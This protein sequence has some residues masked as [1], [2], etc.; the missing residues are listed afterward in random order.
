MMTIADGTIKVPPH[1]S[2]HFIYLIAT[3][4]ASLG[5]GTLPRGGARLVNTEMSGQE[6]RPI[7]HVR[8]QTRDS[9]IRERVSR[10]SRLH[11]VRVVSK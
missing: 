2:M 10:T 9:N 6:H 8:F 3:N 7:V 1:T 11:V 5:G 4:V